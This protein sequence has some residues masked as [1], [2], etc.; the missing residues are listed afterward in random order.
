MGRF[1]KPS[2]KKIAVIGGSSGIGYGAASILLE[3]GAHVIIISSSEEKVEDAVTRLN[4]YPHVS[5]RVADV[6]DEKATTELLLSLAPLDHVVFSS[7]DRII[8]GNFADADLDEARHLFGVKFW[9]SIVVAK[10]L[11]KHDI[12]T[13]GG[14]LTL[15]SGGA[16]LRP[17][18][19]AAL[20]SALNGGL[21]TITQALADELKDKKVRVNT[22]VPG[23]VITELWDK[24]GKSKEEQK[25]IFDKGARELSVGF[26]AT[27]EDIAEAYLYAV[28]ADYANGSTIVIDGG[29]QLN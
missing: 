23:L 9:G 21:I 28:R 27:P 25:E 5:G 29:G 13:P 22:V 12:V 6:R 11:A 19:G 1:D 26:V 24:Q 2:G 14:S 8:R 20:G 15:T 4:S 7:V 3:A 16:A 18:K 17:R 10:A